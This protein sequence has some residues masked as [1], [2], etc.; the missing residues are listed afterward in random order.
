NMTTGGGYIERGRE[1]MLVR[2]V[3]LAESL[4]DVRAI[5]VDTTPEGT[6]ITVGSLGEVRFA[7]MIRQGAV[8][9]D[10][11]GEAVIGIA[12]MLYGEN[13]RVVAE[14]LQNAVDELAPSL[15]EG[16]EIDVFYDRTDLVE[17]TLDTVQKNL[18]EGG[19]LVVAVL[20][21]LLGNLR[22]GLI[23][24][25]AIPLS[26]L[27]ALIGMVLAGVSGNLMSLGAIDFGIIIDG[28]IVMIEN[29]MTAIGARRAA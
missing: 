21:L 8:T 19:L 6:P 2:G 1:Q 25:V 23:V 22:G 27:C 15:P 26:M 14:R 13:P 11:E 17:R 4:D 12:M 18:L 29:I 5:V 28:A 7:P 9:R 24:A 20:L 16:V 3:A 10:G